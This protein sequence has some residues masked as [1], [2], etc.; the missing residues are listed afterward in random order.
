MLFLLNLLIMG[1]EVLRVSFGILLKLCFR[2]HVYIT[3]MQSLL[4]GHQN[5]CVVPIFQTSVWIQVGCRSVSDLLQV[6]LALH[7]AI[8]VESV[9][10]SRH[11]NF[12]KTVLV[13]I[14]TF[15]GIR[16]FIQKRV[17]GFQ[18]VLFKPK[19]ISQVH[20][21]DG[22]LGCLLIPWLFVHCFLSQ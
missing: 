4:T 12:N 7:L 3:K 5:W 1:V 8:C 19:C 9:S 16:F 10:C 21:T 22:I 14:W 6:S 13:W 20:E 11:I 15:D 17:N 18:N 2:F